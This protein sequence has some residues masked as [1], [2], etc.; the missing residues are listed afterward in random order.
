VVPVAPL[1]PGR[2]AL[3]TAVR[4][5]RGR[6]VRWT[7]L[8]AT[9]AGTS[10][11]APALLAAAMDAALQG[12]ADGAV[13]V[14]GVSMLFEATVVTASTLTGTRFQARATANLRHRIIGDILARGLR[15]PARAP[16]GD[17]LSRLSVDASAAGRTVPVVIHTAVSLAVVLGALVA[18]AFIDWLLVAVFLLGAALLGVVVRT[19]VGRV[20]D[21]FARYRQAQAALSARLVEALA[22]ARTIR[23]CASLDR[24]I[25]RVLEPVSD[26]STAGRDSWRLQRSTGWRMQLIFP[27][28]EIV[29]FAVAGMRLVS[30]AITPGA[31]VAVVGYVR[32]ALGLF[33][34]VDELFALGE[35]RAGA[36]RAGEL[37]GGSSPAPPPGNRRVRLRHGAIELDGVTVYGETG[38]L[39]DEVDLDIPA[40]HSLAVVGASGSGKSTLALV[41]G[42]LIAPDRG[43]VRIGGV[44]LAELAP[45][46]LR[47]AVAYAFERP[48]LLGH[49]VDDVIALGAP[50][51]GAPARVMA[52]SAAQAHGFVLRLPYGYHTPMSLAPM[53]GGEIQRLGLA[54][55]FSQGE[56][57]LILDDATASLDTATEARVAAA[58]ERLRRGRTCLIITHRL[59]TAARADRVAWFEGGRPLMVATH[60]ELWRNPGYRAVF[61]PQQ[62]TS[63]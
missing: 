53:S 42:G 49:T 16:V 61:A 21:V 41:A 32:L 57:V 13:W 4:G 47:R 6:I 2:A 54:R 17:V 19:F 30:G 56:L 34:H 37:L 35:S 5:Q 50:D 14:L 63:G 27:L 39:L 45:A 23:A 24:E 52:A 60:R 26:L 7:V 59:A 62:W 25:D 46:D 22:G 15:E 11:A 33:D 40:G 28:L 3:A 10:L 51:R 9:A 29:L 55:A 1:A 58:L 36:R 48:E 38:A 12:R 44:P 31:L 18:L 8:T 43:T 20:T